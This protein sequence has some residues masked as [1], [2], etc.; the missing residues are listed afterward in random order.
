[1][2]SII[3]TSDASPTNDVHG[4]LPATL[5][6][7]SAAVVLAP[8]AFAQFGLGGPLILFAFALAIVVSVWLASWGSARLKRNHPMLSAL[9]AS[10]GVRMV[11]PF[12]IAL[13]VVLGRSQVAPVESVYYIVPIYLCMLVADVLV[14]IGETRKPGPAARCGDANRS[15]SSGEAV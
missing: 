11:A 15:S 9:F 5:A 7:L 6:T 10:S 3:T 4:S 14:W 1:V 8:F 13:A 12:A 2:A